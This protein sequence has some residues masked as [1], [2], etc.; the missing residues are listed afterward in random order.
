MRKTWETIREVIGKHKNK[1]YI[2]E[3]FCNG[4]ETILGD[5]NIAEGFNNFFSSI[6]PDLAKIIPP[7][8]GNFSSFLGKKVDANF[9]FCQ[10]TPELLTKIAGTLKNKTSFGPDNISSK[11]LKIILPQIVDPLCHLFNL[12]FQ[13]GYIPIQLKLAKV[14]P[15]FKSG[16]KHS[17]TNYRPIS[18]LSSIS[19]LLEKIVAKQMVGFLNKHHIL[20]ANQY[21][22]RKG[23]STIHPVM[24]FLDKIFT[25]LNKP[26][27]DYSLGI[28]CDLKKAFDTVDFDILLSK[29][30]HYGFR[31][32]SQTWFKNY[33][34]NRK[35]YVSIN[36]Q[37]SQE[38]ELHCGVPQG[39]VLGPLLFLVFIND[40]PNCTKL[41]T[42][43]FADDTTFQVSGKDLPT[44]FQTA[45]TELNKAAVWFQ[46]NKLTLNVS[47]TKFIL[48][49]KKQMTVD[50][51]N[52]KL[53][54]G[55]ELVERIGFDCQTQFFKFV[56]LHLDEYLTWDH[57]INHVH[58]RLAS[59]NFA[60]NSAKNFLPQDTRLKLYNSLFKSHLE[61]GILAWG[62]V[63]TSKI[64]GL[65]NLQKK[66]V[67]N[68]ANKN[69]LSHTDPIFSSLKILKFADLFTYNAIVFMHKFAFGKQ[70]KTFDNMFQPLG[71]NNRTGNYQ[72]ASYKTTFF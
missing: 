1:I 40:L 60:I 43:L 54:I 65:I 70:P 13:T 41:F 39:S 22:F 21:G 24:Q 11:L 38:K 14:V 69:R 51:K 48:F 7:S 28:F 5:K 49:R 18:L 67:R 72:L 36:G 30:N 46:V 20:Y 6:G 27:P 25:A 2:P 31:G 57:H 10:V 19:K 52:L 23:H 3:Y 50:L 42:I 9:I 62:G 34:H 4:E 16:D 26:Q 15:V 71:A 64:K 45:N 56:G 12:S 29:M 32:I 53:Q 63:P 66:C 35:Q 44:L 37:D 47:K 58:G 59:G 55:Y 61:Y 68:V 8:A 33:L 17:F